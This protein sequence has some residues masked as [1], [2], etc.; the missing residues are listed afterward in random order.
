VVTPVVVVLAMLELH[1]VA[2]QVLVGPHIRVEMVSP[3]QL[4]QHPKLVVV[5]VVPEV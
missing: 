3:I 4:S 1:L 5:V 2:R